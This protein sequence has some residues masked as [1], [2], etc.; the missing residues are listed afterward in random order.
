MI[1]NITRRRLIDLI[2]FMQYDII[3]SILKKGEK[4]KFVEKVK[5]ELEKIEKEFRQIFL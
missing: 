2:R 5:Q 4:T 1:P 3:F